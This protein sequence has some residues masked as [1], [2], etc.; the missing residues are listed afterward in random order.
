VKVIR[1][2][3]HAQKWQHEWIN[4]NISTCINGTDFLLEVSL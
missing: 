3:E 4:T 2:S 1:T